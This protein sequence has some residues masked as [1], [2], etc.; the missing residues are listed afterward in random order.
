MVEITAESALKLLQT[1]QVA[2]W[3]GRADDMLHIAERTL[4]PFLDLFIRLWLAQIFWVSGVLKVSNWDTALALAANEYP[5]SWLTP[6][7][8]AYLGAAIELICPIFLALGLATRLAVIPLL[9]LSLVIQ[10]EYRQINE[11]LFW[12]VLF[13]WYV[14]MGAGSISLDRALG[15]GLAESALPFAKSFS[16]L[17]AA[18][19]RYVG[20]LYCLFIRG[21][22]AWF[23]F[24]L[25]APN[26]LVLAPLLHLVIPLLLLTGLATRIAALGAAV[27]LAGMA[28]AMPGTDLFYGLMLLALI[29]LNGPGSLSVDYW[30]RQRLYRLFPRLEGMATA[31]DS[32]PQVVVVGAGFGGL[33][34]A[35]GLRT[36]ACRVTIIDRRNYHLFQPLLYQVA[37]A[38]LSP[39]DIA[40]PIRELFRDQDNARVL[41]GEVTGVDVQAREVILGRRRIPYDYL[42]LASGARHSHFG[43]HE[44]EPWAPGLKKIEDAT[45]I[46]RQLLLAFEQA[47]N[48]PDPQEQRRLLTFVIVGGGPT[49]VELAGAIA[50]L[51]RHGMEG[52]FRN[53]DPAAARVILIEAGPR[54]LTAFPQKLSSIAENSLTELGVE[55]LTNGRVE[56]V[57]QEGVILAG[58]RIEARTVFWAAGVMASPAAQW[59]KGEADRAG[60]LK[61]RPDL[62]LPGLPNVFA[63]GDTAYA[64]AWNGRS[65]PGLAP[66]AKQGGTYVAQV[67]RAR[68]QGRQSPGPF[69][70]RHKGSLATIGRKAAVADFGWFSLSGTFAWWLWGIVHIFFLAGMRNRMGV[71]LEW[72]WAYLTFR[73]G[74]RL[75]TGGKGEMGG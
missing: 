74:T 59:V 62:S 51:A 12:A 60:R 70:Y 16:R 10:I 14:V 72:F 41:L 2:R 22:M 7:A 26:H 19:T 64:K 52:E 38:V 65:V 42:V 20:P 28:P 8:A 53:I 4:T 6:V 37:T 46:R 24:N 29:F 63:I 9:I 34:V 67:I 27:W 75:I 69:R 33:S 57:D 35:R 3:M 47:E 45:D 18:I 31:L 56:H 55:V 43:R 25:A 30:I 61:V 11:H 58:G 40:T 50:E 13:G 21:F 71:A 48:T 23:L 68:L 73:R 49:G 66:A 15:R 39:A 36:A 54:L 44:W 5:V 32:L 17:F 1:Q